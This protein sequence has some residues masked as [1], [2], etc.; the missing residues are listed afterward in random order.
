M[1]RMTELAKM[2]DTTALAAQYDRSAKKL[3]SFKAV[4]AWILKCCVKEFASLSVDEIVDKC[5]TGE[6]EISEH[7]VHRDHLNR[8]FNGDKQLLML[9][10]ESSSVNEGTVYYDVRFNAV[11][12]G[13][14]EPVTLII[15]IEIQNDDK[16]GYDLVTRGMYYCSRMISEQYG[17]VFA[18]GHYEKMCKVYS[19]WICPS[20]PDCRKNGIYRYYTVEEPVMGERYVKKKSY[21][22]SEVLV[23]NLGVGENNVESDILCLLNT[24][25]SNTVRPDEK[26]RILSEKYNIA[27]TT[28]METEVRHMCNLGSTIESM[29]VR[30]GIT[31]G[32]AEGIDEGI[33]IG[34]FRT[35]AKYYRKGKISIEEASGD[36]NMTKEE[37]LKKLE[38]LPLED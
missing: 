32:K 1:K 3:L 21:D 13:K 34:E 16:P 29:A 35:T 28:E 26:K 17:T 12:P 38:N 36:L 18:S 10:S 33:D 37:F 14:E 7:S 27:M 11:V 30:K 22:L 20:T 25:F 15:N 31:V 4:D 23:L 2:I 24:L 19:I 6:P 9:N 8:K 5:L